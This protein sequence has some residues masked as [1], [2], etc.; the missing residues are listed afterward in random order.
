MKI[1][2]AA[3]FAV[4]LALV[5]LA[6]AAFGVK[7]I[8]DTNYIREFAKNKPDVYIVTS[9][10]AAA[11][12]AKAFQNAILRQMDNKHQASDLPILSI[13]QAETAANSDKNFGKSPVVFLLVGSEMTEPLPPTLA[14]ILPEPLQDT[15]EKVSLIA[16]SLSGAKRQQVFTIEMFAPDA[17]RLQKIYA[18]FLQRSAENFRQLPFDQQYKSNKLALFS[19]PADR[20]LAENWGSIS[21]ANTWN[22]L[23]WH[24]IADYANLP[25]DQLTERTQAFFIDRSSNDPTPGPS[26]KILAAHRILPTSIIIDRQLPTSDTDDDSACVVFSAPSRLI[27]QR[28]V[29]R[30]PDLA[31][32]DG[33]KSQDEAVDLRAIAHTT[34]LLGGNIPDGEKEAIRLLMAKDIRSMLDIDVEERGSGMQVLENEVTLEQ[35]QGATDTSNS[36]RRK[37]G[38]R[39]VWLFTVTDYGGE[40]A[41]AHAERQITPAPAPFPI[42]EPSEPGRG[43]GLFGGHKKSDDEYARDMAQ[44]RADHADWEN[45]KRDYDYQVQNADYRW[46]REVDSLTQ[47]RVQG[48][49]RLV[50]L[51]E[52]G[53]VLWEHD[54]QGQDQQRGLYRSDTVSVRGL[55]SSPS[56]LDTPPT[57]DNCSEDLLHAAVQNASADALGALQE[58]ALL[59]SS[60]TVASDGVG[61]PASLEGAGGN[62]ENES[63]APTSATQGPGAQVADIADGVV[64][65]TIGKTAGVRIGD[66]VTI[67]LK[68]RQITNPTTGA[69]LVT[70]VID[71]IVLR[72]TTVGVCADCVPLT[73]AD[74]EKI[75]QVTKGMPVRWTRSAP[76]HAASKA[77][78]PV[79]KAARKPHKSYRVH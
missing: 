46:A 54:C 55:D 50:D 42:A 70:R 15:H 72:V 19:S 31:S 60:G 16:S 24:D 29:K 32:L 61:A 4:A 34:L 8:A 33:V 75:S 39:Y 79:H 9:G 3:A 17:E 36:L 49:L 57:S 10:P 5:A 51:K 12:I 7:S 77:A 76:S 68:S 27:L 69:V 66:R 40:T 43:G 63:G 45:K 64:T 11:E 62:S 18:I 44:Y 71:Q 74:S 37:V 58:T 13:S 52:N 23:A 28:K 78:K 41:Y 20:D 30:Y 67:P 26:G 35:L 65:L 47:A 48:I 38:L 22:D 2:K 56:S 6:S 53:K 73:P 59:P 1:P 14:S 25:P 21:N